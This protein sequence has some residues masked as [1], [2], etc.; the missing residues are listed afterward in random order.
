MSATTMTN[1]AY[2]GIWGVL[3]AL[4]LV[5]IGVEAMEMSRVVT[6]LILVTAM[7]TKATLI[8][9]WF[10]H[11][12]WETMVFMVLVVSSIVLTSAFMFFLLIPDAL[13]T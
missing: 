10:M 4:T 6:V 7:M 2:W 11:L 3:L 5:M 12:R 8:A 1:R 9:G 13:G